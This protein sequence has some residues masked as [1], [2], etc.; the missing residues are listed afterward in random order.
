VRATLHSENFVMSMAFTTCVAAVA[1]EDLAHLRHAKLATPS[2]A[3]MALAL[4][5]GRRLV[6][7]VPT[8]SHRAPR[9]DDADDAALFLALAPTNVSEL[10]V[11]LSLPPAE[12][13]GIAAALEGNRCHGFLRRL[14]L[15]A[16]HMS[17][18]E[19]AALLA[20]TGGL[21][22]LRSLRCVGA[23]AGALLAAVGGALRGLTANG[24]GPG[25]HLGQMP[26]LRRVDFSASDAVT[27]IDLSQLGRLR[28]VGNDFGTDCPALRDVRLPATVTSIGRNFLC[29]CGAMAA[30]LDLSHLTALQTV[31]DFFACCST[32]PALRLPPSVTTI[33]R[34]VIAGCVN[35]AASLDLSHLTRLQGV[36]DEFAARSSVPGVR[37]PASVTSIG[38]KFVA[39]CEAATGVLDLSHLTRLQ[40]V[41]ASFAR[42]SPVADVLLPAGFGAVGAFFLHGCP[43]CDKVLRRSL[44]LA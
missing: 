18:G 7:T 5:G 37:L 24:A 11:L 30:P 16:L 19:T 21:A 3:F 27:S 2:A 22:H 13:A 25:V 34:N 42:F 39:D 40:S 1:V 23:G 29:G 28:R 31:S 20:A 32:V 17:G 38:A 44:G 33:G 4:C 43:C 35:I 10:A 15:P 41:G 36:G 14:D 9:G 8:D 6:V 12:W 26:L